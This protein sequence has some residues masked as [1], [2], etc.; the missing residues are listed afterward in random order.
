MKTYR[1]WIDDPESA[2]RI[3]AESPMAAAEAY[4]RCHL[5]PGF[6]PEEVFVQDMRP[7]SLALRFSV[8][9]EIKV[10]CSVQMLFDSPAMADENQVSK[11]LSNA[12]RRIPME[13]PGEKCR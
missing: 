6:G 2:A 12:E 3:K 8:F 10:E 5:E 1:V 11:V 7:G 4:G 9:L 13:T